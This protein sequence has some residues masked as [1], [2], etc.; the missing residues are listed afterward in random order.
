MICLVLGMYHDLSSPIVS[1][2]QQLRHHPMSYP[3]SK[4]KRAPD[5]SPPTSSNRLPSYPSN[6]NQHQPKKPKFDPR[7]PSTLLAEDTRSGDALD[8]AV[9]DLDE[10]GAG[11]FKVKRGA[12]KIE[13]YDSDSS[14]EGYERKVV[15]EEKKRK[16]VQ[17]DEDDDM[18]GG[19]DGDDNDEE[20]VAAGKVA[21]KKG[22]KEVRFLSLDEIEGQE[23]DNE[24]EHV[25]ITQ[26][27]GKGKGKDDDMS[28]SESESDDPEAHVADDVANLDPELGLGSLKKHA[29]K[30]DA[31]NMRSEMEEGRFDATGNFIRNAADLDAVHDSWLDGVS[32][33]E[34]KRAKEAHEKREEEIRRK[35]RAADEILTSDMLSTLI[36]GMET[37]ETILEALAR[38]GKER[39][40]K[41]AQA[42]KDAG[43][44]NGLAGGKKIPKWKQKKR[45]VTAAADE[46]EV[47]GVVHQPTAEEEQVQKV[48]KH[49]KNQIET[50]TGAA[51][52]LLTR[53]QLE[54]YDD[55]REMLMRQYKRET[56]EDW[57]PSGE[58]QRSPSPLSRKAVDTEP[59]ADNPETANNRDRKEGG[60]Q[61]EYRW[62]DGR[63]DGS[64]YGPFSGEHMTAWNQHG[65]FGEGVEFRKAN[66]NAG[67]TL[68][69]DFN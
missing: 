8:D 25:H 47:E 21:P 7:N 3:P 58:V 49:Y 41:V 60:V 66:G 22:R 10:I 67:W 30:L 33:K 45:T 50:L 51:D 42:E 56:G 61:W 27:N 46:M 24:T 12:V 40:K 55:T 28:E 36:F 38:L 14:N 52:A 13:G 53:G 19:G 35:A 23:S 65:F 1:P 18:F 4:S 68:V 6:P 69:A 9:L 2:A 16:G 34:M 29:P 15:T 11:G 59:P 48:D 63:D 17:D 43:L 62:I 54:I 32:R 20:G 5:Y 44:K 39:K 64:V 37:G 31:F 26:P 57:K